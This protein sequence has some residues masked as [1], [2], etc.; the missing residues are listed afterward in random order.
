MWE[1]AYRGAGQDVVGGAWEVAG[2]V[3]EVD[4]GGAREVDWWNVGK[5]YPQCDWGK[6]KLKKC[7]IYCCYCLCI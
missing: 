6:Y 7:V 3:R 5:V 1:G 2:E 4:W